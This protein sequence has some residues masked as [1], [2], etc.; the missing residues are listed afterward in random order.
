MMNIYQKFRRNSNVSF[1]S[2]SSY[3]QKILSK[4]SASL[5]GFVSLFI[6]TYFYQN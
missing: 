1:K 6:G 4:T 2:K 3:Q 5:F